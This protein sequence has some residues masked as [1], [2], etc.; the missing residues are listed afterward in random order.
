MDVKKFAQMALGGFL[1]ALLCILAYQ[2][3]LDHRRI[4]Q[5]EVALIQIANVL[6]SGRQK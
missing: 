1:G 2:A 3:Y 6:N 4:Q 5:H